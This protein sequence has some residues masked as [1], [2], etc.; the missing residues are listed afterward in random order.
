MP[1]FW[2]DADSFIEPY[3][4]PYRFETLPQF[5]DFL[6]QKAEEGI[7]ASPE[8][9]LEKELTADDPKDSDALEK[10]A[11]PLKGIMFLG[12]DESVQACYREIVQYVQSNSI[13][14]PHWVTKF[15]DGVDPWV[16]AYAKAHGGRVVTFEKPQPEAKKPK[17]PDVAKH[18][19]VKCIT[20]YDMLAELKVKF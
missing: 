19:K 20:V 16:I 18:F 10:W 13:Y 11:M 12:A 3:R 2:M 9:L 5:W 1:D 15:L 17:I 7:I 14:K 6:K 4:G 8:L